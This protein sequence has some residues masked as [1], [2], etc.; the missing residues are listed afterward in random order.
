MQGL[1]GVVK[2]RMEAAVRV[3]DR[4]EASS[5]MSPILF[6]FDPPGSSR[7]RRR[8]ILTRMDAPEDREH[9]DRSIDC[10]RCEAVCCRLKVVLLPGDRVPAR[11]LSGDEQGLPVLAKNEE[12][13]CAALDPQHM[14]CT[15]YDDR[16]SLCREFAMGGESCR[17]ERAD[18]AGTAPEVR[19]APPTARRRR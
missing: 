12:G 1:P 6:L 18:W 11:Y 14:R 5:P 9:I 15:I 17:Q 2:R 10:R 13:W 4:S 16:P 7:R 3:G 8:A 19:V